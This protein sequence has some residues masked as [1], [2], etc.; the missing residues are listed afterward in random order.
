MILVLDL[1][2]FNHP[3]SSILEPNTPNCTPDCL[4]CRLHIG[5]QYTLKTYEQLRQKYPTNHFGDILLEDTRIDGRYGHIFGYFPRKVELK[6]IAL[7][8]N[9]NPNSRTITVRIAD[10]EYFGPEASLNLFFPLEV[11][12][13]A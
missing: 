13:F 8:R 1:D 5:S 2:R 10:P 11:L 4:C 12:S 7:R 9:S 6:D 3:S